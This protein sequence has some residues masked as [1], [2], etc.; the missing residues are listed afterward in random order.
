M[1]TPMDELDRIEVSREAHELAARHGANAH[2]HAAKLAAE[3]L[4]EGKVEECELWKA[5]EA[6]LSPRG[7]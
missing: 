2:N 4:A 5:V 1:L 6:Y 7:K 3:A